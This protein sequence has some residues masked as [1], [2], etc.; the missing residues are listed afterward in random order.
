MRGGGLVLTSVIQN[1][2][3]ST[4]ISCPSGYTAVLASCQ[5][6]VNV[7]LNDI[8][9]PLPPGASGWADYLTPTVSNATGV[10]C[11]VGVGN[12]SQA[13]LRCAQL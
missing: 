10:H 9:S 4:D 11:D 3:A 1:Y 8:N 2:T 7:V 5:A 13:Q 6:G 12:Q